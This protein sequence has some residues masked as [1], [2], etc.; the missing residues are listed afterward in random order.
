MNPTRSDADPF[1]FALPQL[2]CI[3]AFAAALGT[4]DHGT[5][6]LFKD[7]TFVACDEPKS[8]TAAATHGDGDAAP[9]VTASAGF[10]AAT[11]SGAFETVD[12]GM[13]TANAHVTMAMPFDTYSPLTVADEDAPVLES[14]DGL[15]TSAAADAM[16]T[17]AT[18]IH[19][20]DAAVAIKSFEAIVPFLAHP[21]IGRARQHVGSPFETPPDAIL[22]LPVPAAETVEPAA[23]V[24]SVATAAVASENEPATP[25]PTARKPRA[26]TRSTTATGKSTAK[27]PTTRAATAA[28]AAAAKADNPTIALNSRKT[29]V[30]CLTLAEQERAWPK[31][32]IAPTAPIN[33]VRGAKGKK[34]TAFEAQMNLTE[35]AILQMPQADQKRIR[36]T[37][38]ARMSRARKEAR[39]Q[40]LE[41]EC[42]VLTE[43]VET[44]E[45]KYQAALERI[46]ELEEVLQGR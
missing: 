18:T 1:L 19:G 11:M 43:K 38:S 7:F 35:E 40:A 44:V 14:G 32:F 30:K 25:S 20:F 37:I 5:A 33:P 45:R 24:E 10:D 21:T 28:A 23:A 26:T 31:G 2:G 16:A 6:D 27:K 22:G 8:T 41:E 42:R 34:R 12:L 13:P 29:A 46:R 3:D 9:T 39:V 36:N 17:A 15:A 4:K